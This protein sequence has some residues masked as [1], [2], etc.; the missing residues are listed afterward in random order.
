EEPWV[1]AGT[2]VAEYTLGNMRESQQA[3]DALTQQYAAGYAFQIAAIH[4]WRG[5]NDQAFEWLQ[6]AYAQHDAGMAR[7]RYDPTIASLRD[8][9]RFAA[10]VKNM[11]FPE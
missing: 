8:D 6:R 4:A 7:L 10:L 11:D 5:E 1:L 3:L 9:P 2:A